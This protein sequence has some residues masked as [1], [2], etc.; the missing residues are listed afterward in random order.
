[1]CKNNEQRDDQCG[2]LPALIHRPLG[3]NKGMSIA[4]LNIN[5]LRAYIDEVAL[6][7]QNLGIH[8]LVL[9]ENKLGPSFPGG[10][11]AINGY[12]QERLDRTC[13][14]GGVSIYIRNSIN[15][16]RR[17]DLPRGDLELICIQVLPSLNKPFLLLAW[18]RPPSDTVETFHKLDKFLAF[19]ASEDKEIILLGDTN[20]DLTNKPGDLNVDSN[21]RHLCSLY[22]LYIF[23]QHIMNPTRVTL[24]TSSI[25]D[26]IATTCARN[27]SDSGVHKVT[28]SDHYMVFCVPSSMVRY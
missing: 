14:G 17:T 15:Y 24:T 1:M 27:M 6:L 8:N 11:T 12:E 28:M 10:L 3:L 19:L 23:H 16:K 26:H 2:G 18:Y 25:I 21:T 4:S 9:C 5:G 13:H 22:D 20:C 7:M